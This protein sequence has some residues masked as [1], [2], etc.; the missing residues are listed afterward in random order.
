[1][2]KGDKQMK[3]Y[4]VVYMSPYLMHERFRCS[5]KNKRD[6]KKQCVEC[7]GVEAKDIVEVEEEK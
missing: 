5:A 7:M 4:C 6:A 1:M 3:Q 2:D